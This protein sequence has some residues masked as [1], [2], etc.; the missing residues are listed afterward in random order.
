[1]K[2]WEFAEREFGSTPFTTGELYDLLGQDRLPPVVQ[3]ASG[4]G[5]TAAL[6]SLGKV[7]QFTPEIDRV[8]TLKGASLWKVKP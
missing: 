7:L 1:M 6:R 8:S 3:H 4:R 5:R 2:I